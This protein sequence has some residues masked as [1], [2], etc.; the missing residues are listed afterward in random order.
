M[1]T[2]EDLRKNPL[3]REARIT[4]ESQMDDATDMDTHLFDT[5]SVLL[6]LEDHIDS[7]MEESHF[8]RLV[9]KAVK[10]VQP[11]R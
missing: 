6:A 2:L 1:T 4:M 11:H 7:V 9:A 8:E 10:P 5:W 3:Y